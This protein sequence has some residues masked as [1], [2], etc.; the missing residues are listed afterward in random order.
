MRL[1]SRGEREG[2]RDQN[3]GAQ[4]VGDKLLRKKAQRTG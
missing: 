1:E 2:S 3:E 4:R